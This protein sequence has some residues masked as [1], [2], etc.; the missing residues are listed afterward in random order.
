MSVIHLI[1]PLLLWLPHAAWSDVS[2]PLLEQVSIAP[3]VDLH[4]WFH[5]SLDGMQTLLAQQFDTDPFRGTRAA[6]SNFV[7]TGQAWALLIGFVI[8]YIVR[9]LT[10]YG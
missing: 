3:S 10:T 9:G 7:R 5:H 8:G 4:H 2:Q 6:F 1:D